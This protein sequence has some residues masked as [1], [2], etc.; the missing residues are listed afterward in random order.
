MERL[1]LIIVLSL[2]PAI[3]FAQEKWTLKKNENGIAVYTRKL[4]SE[5][6]KEIR[7]VCEF[8][9]SADKLIE[10]LQDVNHHKEWVYKTTESYLISRK[11]KD[12]LFYYSKISLPWPA[13][14]RDAVVQLSF[15]KDTV[16]KIL[17]IAVRSIPNLLPEKPGLIRVPYSLG[18]YDV[19]TLPNN[20]IKIDY[21]LSINP[22]GSLPAWLVNYTA[23]I[24][25]Y[26][27]F[28]K[29]KELVE[30]KSS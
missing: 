15:A 2:V 25:P 29:L 8:E 28:K 19:T 14:N 13:S 27:T 21:T 18:L 1:R 10:V 30:K 26:N 12:T 4:N 16:H 9:A 11:N 22:G 6:F 5:K 20:R 3:C 24:G 23:T 7:V 17:R